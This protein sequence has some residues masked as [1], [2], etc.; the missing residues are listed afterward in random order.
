METAAL[1]KGLVL[2][3]DGEE[4]IEEGLGFGVPVVKYHDKTS[5]SIYADVSIQECDYGILVQK[6]YVWIQFQKRFGVAPTL[7]TASIL[8]GEN[9]SQRYT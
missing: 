6:R 5:F 9:G 3:L 1:Q 8:R 4:L 2:V 7:T